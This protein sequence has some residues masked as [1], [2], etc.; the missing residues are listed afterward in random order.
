M[1][2]TKYEY[3]RESAE[4]NGKEQNVNG[5]TWAM[6]RGALYCAPFLLAIFVSSAPDIYY[7]THIHK[8]GTNGTARE[9][10]KKLQHS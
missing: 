5:D 7:N 8:C 2:W 6:A 3:E 4:V 1:P 10:K 9:W